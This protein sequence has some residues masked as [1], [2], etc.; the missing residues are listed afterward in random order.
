VAANF[1]GLFSFSQNSMSRPVISSLA[2]A[3]VKVGLGILLVQRF[4]LGGVLAASI[5]ASVI[6]LILIGSKLYKNRTLAIRDFRAFV[7]IG[8]TSIIIPI[9][10]KFSTDSH[11]IPFFIIGAVLTAVVWVTFVFTLMKVTARRALELS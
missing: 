4:G 10:F 9:L 7:L 6:P 3:V 5:L 11:E 2:Q 8:V 1:M